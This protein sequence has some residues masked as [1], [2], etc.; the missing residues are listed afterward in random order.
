[1]WTRKVFGRFAG[2]L[3]MFELPATSGEKNDREITFLGII[4][5]VR[6]LSNL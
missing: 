1:M 3:S 2:S 5:R 6:T 4:S